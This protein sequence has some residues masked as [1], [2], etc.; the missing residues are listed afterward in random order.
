MILSKEYAINGWLE[1]RARVW[2]EEINR[3]EY[4]RD[5]VIEL[6]HIPGCVAAMRPILAN[7]VSFPGVIAIS[8]ASR[9]R[10]HAM[11]SGQNRPSSSLR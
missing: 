10:R 4:G 1:A 11:K 2:N 7:P 8:I 9:R 3:G 6:I 5:A